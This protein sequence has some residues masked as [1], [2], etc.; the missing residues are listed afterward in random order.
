MHFFSYGEFVATQ[1]FCP[2]D[3]SV[4]ER[5]NGAIWRISQQDNLYRVKDSR[6][7]RVTVCYTRSGS[8]GYVWNAGDDSGWSGPFDSFDDAMDHADV[9]VFGG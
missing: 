3:P 8:I 5:N 4:V 7:I 1:G 9:K 2:A 6:S